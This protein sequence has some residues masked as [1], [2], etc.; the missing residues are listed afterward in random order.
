MKEAK[1]I[2]DAIKEFQKTIAAHL[3]ALEKEVKFLIKRKETNNN[4]IE[5][6]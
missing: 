4:N 3:P 1:E 5:H 6:L 2:A